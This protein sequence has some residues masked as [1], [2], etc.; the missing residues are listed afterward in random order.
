M[1]KI[2]RITDT[3]NG[4]IQLSNGRTISYPP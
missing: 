1:E 2:P 4:T 3:D